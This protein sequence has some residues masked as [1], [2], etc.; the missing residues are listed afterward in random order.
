MNTNKKVI[1]GLILVVLVGALIWYFVARNS[2]TLPPVSVDNG[3]EA[4]VID[5][6]EGVYR[7]DDSWVK[8]T[9]EDEKAPGEGEYINIETRVDV[10]GEDWD[11]MPLE[12]VVFWFSH[13]GGGSG[14]FNYVGVAMNTRGGFIG[15]TKSYFVGDRIK[16]TDLRYDGD[17]VFTI[18]YKDRAEGEPMANAPTVNKTLKLRYDAASEALVLAE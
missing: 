1:G 10:G 17:G 14:T 16:P 5:Y 13:D 8:I 4:Y 18:R 9:A 3:E 11:G 6:K 7:V 15:T 12:D 2:Q